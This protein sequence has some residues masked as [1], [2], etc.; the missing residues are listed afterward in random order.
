ML[1]S[2]YVA[3][4]NDWLYVPGMTRLMFASRVRFV[5]VKLLTARG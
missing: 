4:E 2:M 5:I 1:K 3:N